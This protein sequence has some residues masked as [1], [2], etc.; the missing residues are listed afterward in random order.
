MLAFNPARFGKIQPRADRKPAMCPK[1]LF[2]RT[3]NGQKRARQ[4]NYQEFKF[5]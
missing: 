1:K 2:R 3:E 5:Y 4:Q